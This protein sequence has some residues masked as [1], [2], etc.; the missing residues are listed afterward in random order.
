MMA[1]SKSSGFSWECAGLP[2]VCPLLRLD[3]YE[4][5][6]WGVPICGQAFLTIGSAGKTTTHV[7]KLWAPKTLLHEGQASG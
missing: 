3:D 1:P 7:C 5:S 6:A 2:T 4:G